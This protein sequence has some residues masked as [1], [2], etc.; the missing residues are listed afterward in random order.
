MSGNLVLWFA[1]FAALVFFA[2]ANAEQFYVKPENLKV[3]SAT[4]LKTNL[5]VVKMNG[6]PWQVYGPL[7]QPYGIPKFAHAHTGWLSDSDAKALTAK[8]QQSLDQIKTS[9]NYVIYDTEADLKAKLVFD[10]QI[11]N[12][13]KNPEEAKR[14]ISLQQ[15]HIKKLKAENP[16]NPQIEDLLS[17]YSVALPLKTADDYEKLVSSNDI[18]KEAR[19]VFEEKRRL[20]EKVKSLKAEK[21][22]HLKKALEKINCTTPNTSMD[23]IKNQVYD[24]NVSIDKFIFDNHEKM[25]CNDPKP[26]EHVDF[27]QATKPSAS[28]ATGV[29]ITRSKKDPKVYYADLNLRFVYRDPRG[30]P[31]AAGPNLDYAYKEYFR[32]LNE[33]LAKVNTKILG[34]DGEKIIIRFYDPAAEESHRETPPPRVNISLYPRVNRP[35]SKDWGVSLSCDAIT[36][37]LFH[38]LGLI[39]EYN[40]YEVSRLGYFVNEN[41]QV[42]SKSGVKHVPIYDC[43]SQGKEDSIMNAHGYAFQTTF[44]A[45]LPS[46]LYPAQFRFLTR[47]QK[48]LDNTK[49]IYAI[50]TQGAYAT[51]VTQGC[52]KKPS[53][54]SQDGEWLK[55]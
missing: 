20:L 39:D 22:E 13:I 17:K 5:I 16:G 4:F 55:K 48:C 30:V 37:E 7:A 32:H 23:E 47:T 35:T 21:S 43:R 25:G 12:S 52:P 50:C 33:C 6:V 54:C 15:V 2:K 18:F 34:P 40:E 8:V 1:T 28:S 44:E 51:S 46:L 45:G 29:R 14:Q 42:V 38:Y 24:L 31:Y 9:G 53:I 3:E 36:H 10:S 49:D 41:G 19:S 26:G 11:P 27:T